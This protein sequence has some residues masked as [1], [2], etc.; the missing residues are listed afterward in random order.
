MVRRLRSVLLGHGLSLILVGSLWLPHWSKR[1]PFNLKIT[2]PLAILF[3]NIFHCTWMTLKAKYVNMSY[4]VA[5]RSSQENGRRAF[6]L[7]PSPLKFRNW[8]HF[9]HHMSWPPLLSFF[10]IFPPLPHRWITPGNSLHYVH[11]QQLQL[12]FICIESFIYLSQGWY[13]F[14]RNL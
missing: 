3:E 12:G 9:L 2:R 6:L 11:F 5:W 13:R 1:K 4:Y 8:Q 7:C 10:S 14:W